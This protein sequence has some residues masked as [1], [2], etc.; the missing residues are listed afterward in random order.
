MAE[1]KGSRRSFLNFV[2]GGGLIA[3]AGSVLYPVVSYLRPPAETG[4][5][6]ASVK[7]GAASDF[8]PGTSAIVKFGR[9]P[10]ILI[11]MDDG[12]FRALSATCTH[13]DCTVQFRSEKRDIWCACHNGVY[14]LRGQNV[15][16]PPPRPLAPYAVNIVDGDVVISRM[17]A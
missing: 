8:A 13:L 6:V 5:D 3:W 17:E 10:V 14:D 2:L 16:G 12:E 7:W 4:G 15:S 1:P 9:K 11:R